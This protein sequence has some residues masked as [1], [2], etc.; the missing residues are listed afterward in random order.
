MTGSSYR[1]RH[2]KKYKKAQ[3]KKGLSFRQEYEPA[4]SFWEEKVL[5]LLILSAAVSVLSEIFPDLIRDL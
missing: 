3:N 1:L 5:F 2:R 4:G